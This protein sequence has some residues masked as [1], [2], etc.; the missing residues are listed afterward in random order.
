MEQPR[1][2]KGYSVYAARWQTAA[3]LSL[4]II[5]LP[6]EEFDHPLVVTVHKREL[7]KLNSPYLFITKDADGAVRVLNQFENILRHELQRGLVVEELKFAPLQ[8]HAEVIPRELL[9]ETF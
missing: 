7:N 1:P 4:L 6:A 5:W 3:N 2:L 9:S 8:M